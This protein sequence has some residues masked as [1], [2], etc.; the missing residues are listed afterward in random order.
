MH[1]R[2][3]QSDCVLIVADTLRRNPT[4][5]FAVS[6]VIG[7]VKDDVAVRSAL[8]R[9]M[10]HGWAEVSQSGRVRSYRWKEPK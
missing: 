5:W 3:T 6:D 8:D 10:A 1:K 2:P 7:R 4:K 9:L